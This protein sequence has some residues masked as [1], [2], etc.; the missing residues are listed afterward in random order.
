MYMPTTDQVAFGTLVFTALAALANAVAAVSIVFLYRSFKLQLTTFKLQLATVEKE[1]EWRKKDLAISITREWNSFT[2]KRRDRIESICRDLFGNA[3]AGGVVNTLGGFYITPISKELAVKIHHCDGGQ[4]I[5]NEKLR[6]LK[7]DITVLLN[8]FE[9]ISIAYQKE[10]LD[11]DIINRLFRFAM[12]NWYSDLKAYLDY[13][14]EAIGHSG[15]QP[16]K[17]LINQWRAN[18]D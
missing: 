18:P 13:V 10:A 7:T 4:D 2:S 8:Y 15:W 9:Y 6:I 11:R 1:Y 3:P 14:E 16:Y 12:T 5:P 17:D